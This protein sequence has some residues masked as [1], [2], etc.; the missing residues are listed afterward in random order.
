LN[1]TGFHKDFWNPVWSFQLGFV[2]KILQ[3][4]PN[5]SKLTNS[6]ETVLHVFSNTFT[7]ST[8]GREKS[9]IIPHFTGID[10]CN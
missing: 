5:T 2:R 9:G 10:V 3:L 7:Y 6:A 4:S 8:G 1:K